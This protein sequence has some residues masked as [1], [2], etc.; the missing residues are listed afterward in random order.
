MKIKTYKVIGKEGANIRALPSSTSK[1]EG[2][3]NTGDKVEI[4]TDFYSQNGETKYLCIP[5]NEH[6]YWTVAANLAEVKESTT[7]TTDKKTVATV[8]EPSTET[9]QSASK[10]VDYKVKVAEAAAKVYPEAIGKKHGGVAAKLVKDLTSMKKYKVLTCN[11][12][13]SIAMQQAGILP[14]GIIVSHTAKRS[15]KKKISDAVKNTKF[16]KH[17]DV[18]WVNKLYKDLPD[19][20]KKAGCVY[21]QNSNACISAGNGYVW[22]CNQSVGHKYIKGEYYRN[23]GYPFTSKILVVVVPRTE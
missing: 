7:T 13:A 22:S 21:Y 12:I 8:K 18:I 1:L 23:S 16:L 9:K 5:Y 6:F 3:L 17:C 10:K 11:R 14:K 4:I 20:Y 19:K 2:H 15:G